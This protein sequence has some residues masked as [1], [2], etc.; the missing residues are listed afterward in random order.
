MAYFPMFISIEGKPCLIVGGGAVAERKCRGLLAFGA[1]VTMIAERF[2]DDDSL[3]NSNQKNGAI[4][5]SLY[6][7]DSDNARAKCSLH[8]ADSGSARTECSL[9]NTEPEAP[10]VFSGPRKIERR[11][12]DGDLAAENW[13]L[14]IAATDDRGVNGRIAALCHER[15]IPVNVADCKEECD[16][17]FP[18]YCMEGEVAVGVTTSGTSPGLASALRARIEE[19]LPG[20]LLEIRKET[21]GNA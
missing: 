15:Q 3:H 17:F 18:A 8:N 4:G 9:H 14:V 21:D 10:V 6:N 1:D 12:Q 19:A 11:F 16:F 2:P 20:W 5:C 13:A 7:A